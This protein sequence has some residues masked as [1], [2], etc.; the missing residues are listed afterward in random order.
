MAAAP[1]VPRLTVLVVEDEP[2]VRVIQRLFLQ[3]AGFEVREAANGAEAV[4]VLRAAPDE[5]DAVLLDVM[6]P[7]MTG[8]DTLPALRAIDPDLPVVFCSGY[9]RG[10][11]AEHIARPGAYTAFLPKPFERGDL[12]AE[13]QRAVAARGGATP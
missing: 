7:V 4:E 5:I 9:D 8:H 2:D 12:V 1:E 11:V 3:R 6:M 13:L 10:E